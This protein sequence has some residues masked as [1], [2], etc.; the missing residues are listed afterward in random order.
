MLTVRVTQLSGARRTRVFKIRGAPP[1]G[2]VASTIGEYLVE[3]FNVGDEIQKAR[4]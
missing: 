1:A 2:L 4:V 3:I